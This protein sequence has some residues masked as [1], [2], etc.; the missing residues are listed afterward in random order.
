MAK[1]SKPRNAFWD[2]FED[3][4]DPR[5]EGRNKTHSL[6]NVLILAV[7]GIACG[8]RSFVGIAEFARMQAEW[9][10]LYLDPFE[11][12]PCRDTFRRVFEALRCDDF[13]KRFIEWVAAL[14]E[15]HSEVVAVDG[16]TVRNSGKGS[17]RA[18]HLV[19]AWAAENRLVLGQV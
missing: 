9:F 14:T 19:S 15:R 3:I 12:T 5:E 7:V 11:R 2:Y 6:R 4:E 16:K 13:E 8:Q 17:Q 10:R 1:T 18:L